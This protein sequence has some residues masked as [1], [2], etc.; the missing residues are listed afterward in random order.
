MKTRGEYSIEFN[1]VNFSSGVYFYEL[2]AGSY[3]SGKKMM[4]LK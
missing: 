1:V 4:L 3:I 2:K